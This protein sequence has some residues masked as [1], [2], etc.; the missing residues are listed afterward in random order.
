MKKENYKKYQKAVKKALKGDRYYPI[1]NDLIEEKEINDITLT[2]KN[3][4]IKS[5]LSFK[6]HSD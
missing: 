2:V 3:Y 1:E 5:G 4:R 6:L